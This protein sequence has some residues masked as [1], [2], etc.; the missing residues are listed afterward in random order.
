MFMC[1]NDMIFWCPTILGS[2]VLSPLVLHSETRF[3]KGLPQ[4]LILGGCLISKHWL[5]KDYMHFHAYPKIAEGKLQ[6]F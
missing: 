1:I 3:D 6:L 2:V 5:S 4:S